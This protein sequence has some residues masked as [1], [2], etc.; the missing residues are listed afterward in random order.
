MTRV[1]AKSGLPVHAAVFAEAV[2]NWKKLPDGDKKAYTEK[3]KVC[4]G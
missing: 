1:E 2:A 4:P 3:F